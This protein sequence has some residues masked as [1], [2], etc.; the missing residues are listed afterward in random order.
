[1][2]DFPSKHDGAQTGVKGVLADYQQA[3]LEQRQR[4]DQEVA[5]AKAAMPQHRAPSNLD[6]T[7]FTKD[8]KDPQSDSDLDDDD[9]DQ[10]FKEYREARM[11]ELAQTGFGVLKDATPDEYVDIVDKHAESGASVVVILVNGSGAS[12]RLAEMVRAEASTRTNAIF[13][14]VQAHDC[15]FADAHVVPILLAYRHGELKHNLVRVVDQFADPLDFERQ[16][17]KKLLDKVFM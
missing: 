6:Q 4:R 2:T 7:M 15:G 11:A 5:A 17:V 13:L 8:E 3:Q 9:D 12:R 16:D 1:M 14:R 10:I